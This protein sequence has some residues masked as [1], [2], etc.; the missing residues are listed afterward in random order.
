MSAFS[1]R[2]LSKF[3]LSSFDLVRCCSRSACF[4]LSALLPAAFVA[5]RPNSCEIVRT[6][7][8]AL[9][10]MSSPS[11]ARKADEVLAMTVRRSMILF[12]LPP[13]KSAASSASMTKKSWRSEGNSSSITCSTPAS[14]GRHEPS[15]S[16]TSSCASSLMRRKSGSSRLLEFLATVVTDR[17][18]S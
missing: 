1:S 12:S 14:Y 13:T 11:K 2:L 7:S 16:L 8:V 10:K 4:S 17:R 15:R 9:S 6:R 3:L 5:A 18:S